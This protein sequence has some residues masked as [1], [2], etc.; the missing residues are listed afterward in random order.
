M[1]DM[2][3]YSYL[4]LLRILFHPEVNEGPEEYELGAGGEDQQ[5]CLNLPVEFVPLH[6]VKQQEQ[7]SEILKTRQI[8]QDSTLR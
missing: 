5:N 8:I 6:L 1:F 4:F 3:H 7:L 2:K